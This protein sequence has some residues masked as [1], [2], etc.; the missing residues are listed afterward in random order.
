MA[1]CLTFV[2]LP[3]IGLKPCF[4][5][6][7]S[8]ALYTERLHECDEVT[9]FSGLWKTWKNHGIKFEVRENLEMSRN[10]LWFIIIKWHLLLAGLPS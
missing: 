1:S 7:K 10:F 6:I 2:E 8:K 4:V 9:G 5:S 3:L